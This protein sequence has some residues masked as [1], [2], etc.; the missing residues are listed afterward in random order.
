MMKL[1][2]VKI[3]RQPNGILDL[4]RGYNETCKNMPT[5]SEDLLSIVWKCMKI[6]RI[7]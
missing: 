1:T 4:K 6:V 5:V 2:T 3:V 7:I